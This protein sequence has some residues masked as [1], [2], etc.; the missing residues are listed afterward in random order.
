MDTVIFVISKLVGLAILPEIWLVAALMLALLAVIRGWRRFARWMLGGGIAFV[1]VVGIFP[2][3]EL[4][5]QPIEQEYPTAPAL[6]R[7]DGIIVLG[8]AEN[9]AASKF[10]GQTQFNDSS[11]RLTGALE[12]ARK[13]PDAQMIAAGGSGSLKGLVVKLKGAESTVAGRFFIDQGLDPARLVMENRSRTT[14]ENARLTLDRLKPTA[15]QRFVLVTS[16]Y[17]MPRAMRSFES[18]GWQN[19]TAWPVDYRSSRFSAGI[20]WNFANN[21]NLLNKGVKEWVGRIAYKIL[22]R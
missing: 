9:P 17:H 16:A 18:A 14:A 13:F 5:I 12:L 4:L 1:L 6:D 21:L 11:E 3:G 22:G 20:G 15:A 10:W 7:V 8:G 19:L 2:I